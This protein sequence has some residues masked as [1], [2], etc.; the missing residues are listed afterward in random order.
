MWEFNN[1]EEAPDVLD[2]SYPILHWELVT[3]EP[4]ASD[5]PVIKNYRPTYDGLL[6]ISGNISTL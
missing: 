1:P 6:V 2:V 5:A 3:S 4:V